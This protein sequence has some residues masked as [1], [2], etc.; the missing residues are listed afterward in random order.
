MAI[1]PEQLEKYWAANPEK[2]AEAA[3]AN[4]TAFAPNPTAFWPKAT[5]PAP[6]PTMTTPVDIGNSI[7]VSESTTSTGAVPFTGTSLM[8]ETAEELRALQAASGPNGAGIPDV[9]YSQALADEQ[10][11][12]VRDKPLAPSDVA[13]QYAQQMVS[14]GEENPYS[15]PPAG[16]GLMAPAADF[17]TWV[18]TPEGQEWAKNDPEMQAALKDKMLY[19]SAEEV[20]DAVYENE[21]PVKQYTNEQKTN[22]DHMLKMANEGTATAG[23]IDY[24]KKHGL[25]NQE[26]A[27]DQ[28]FA[29]G[30]FDFI[31]ENG[32]DALT[33]EQQA[34]VGQNWNNENLTEEQRDKAWSY[35]PVQQQ[36][37]TYEELSKSQ[38][39]G[40]EKMGVIN[41]TWGSWHQMAINDPESFKPWESQNI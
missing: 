5:A 36:T 13:W 19:G 30:V 31:D 27:N 2:L 41:D 24:L 3:A 9:T 20:V 38:G 37:D 22:I 15:G 33:P 17:E 16:S 1:T 32:F 12:V 21:E 39:S 35:N 8:P 40:K 29:D 4:P 11:G 25:Y 10:M 28:Q 7:M 23:M 6:T 18:Q 14:N 26:Q 34:L